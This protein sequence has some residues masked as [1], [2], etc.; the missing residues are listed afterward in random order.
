MDQETQTALNQIVEK[1]D[2]MIA[3]LDYLL[4]QE[5]ARIDADRENVDQ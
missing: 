2:A 3:K 4:D 5:Q 1:I